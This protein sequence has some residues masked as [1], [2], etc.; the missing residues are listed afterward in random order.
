MNNN[1]NI[2]QNILNKINNN[3]DANKNVLDYFLNNDI[4]ISSIFPNIPYKTDEN[5]TFSSYITLPI[6]KLKKPSL[7]Q[8]E[9]LVSE[10]DDYILFS[11]FGKDIMLSEQYIADNNLMSNKELLNKFR[12]QDILEFQKDL[13]DIMKNSDNYKKELKNISGKEFENLTSLMVNSKNISTIESMDYIPYTEIQERVEKEFS[14]NSVTSMLRAKKVLKKN[15]SYFKNIYSTRN[16][17]SNLYDLFNLH[18]NNTLLYVDEV[19]IYGGNGITSDNKNVSPKTDILIKFF[20]TDKREKDLLLAYENRVNLSDTINIS[21][22]QDKYYGYQNIS[23]NYSNR[24]VSNMQYIRSDILQKITQMSTTEIGNTIANDICDNYITQ[25]INDEKYLSNIEKIEI[26]I[27][28]NETTKSNTDYCKT[29]KSSYKLGNTTSNKI[30][31]LK[32]LYGNF[33]NYEAN[34]NTFISIKNKNDVANINKLLPLLTPISNYNTD[35]LEYA[36]NLNILYSITLKKVKFYNINGRFEFMTFEKVK[37]ER[38]VNYNG[39]Y[40]NKSIPLSTYT[41]SNEQQLRDFIENI[42]KSVFSRIK[43]R[44]NKYELITNIKKQVTENNSISYNTLVEILINKLNKQ[45]GGNETRK[46]QN[47]KNGT[48]YGDKTNKR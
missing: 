41:F 29:F 40:I 6:N 19:S 14:N 23:L 11:S 22:K 38:Y 2:K 45:D 32:F 16:T 4:N 24:K 34:A 28:H 48:K 46:K 3:S 17:S 47:Y 37:N 39:G 36:S 35:I 44:I 13:S 30:D 20:T 25:L 10:G 33:S 1:D 21:L 31:I 12:K 15:Y 7:I 8:E 26:L 43:T 18:D 9:H 42:C 5:S 27:T